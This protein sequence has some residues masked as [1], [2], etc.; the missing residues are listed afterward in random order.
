MERGEFILYRTDDGR[1]EIQLRAE[2][3]TVWLTQAEMTTLFDTT[4][5]NV[6]LHLRNLF[7]EGELLE[8]SVVKDSLTTAADGNRYRTKMFN[9]DAI[10]AAGYFNVMKNKVNYDQGQE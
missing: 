6:S 5:Q 4:K 8:S 2:G 9:L 10:L 3:K 7:K 1:D